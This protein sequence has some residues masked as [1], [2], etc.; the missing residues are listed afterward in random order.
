MSRPVWC[1]TTGREVVVGAGGRL[2][3]LPI[4][5]KVGTSRENWEQK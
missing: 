5:T 3:V 4:L 1:E 2:R